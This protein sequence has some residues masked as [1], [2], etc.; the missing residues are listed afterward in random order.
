MWRQMKM[1]AGWCAIL[2]TFNWCQL[3]N[4]IHSKLWHKSSGLSRQTFTMNVRMYV[5]SRIHLQNLTKHM[6]LNVQR[7]HTKNNSKLTFQDFLTWIFSHNKWRYSANSPICEDR[8]LKLVVKFGSCSPVWDRINVRH[9]AVWMRNVPSGYRDWFWAR[10]MHP[11]A[12]LDCLLIYLISFWLDFIIS[13]EYGRILHVFYIS[14]SGKQQ[15]IW[16]SYLEVEA[17]EVKVITSKLYIA[18]PLQMTGR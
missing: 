10:P 17:P 18:S 13:V 8:K 6:Q 2:C 9:Y 11:S 4:I 15:Q 7:E 12:P 5:S 3:N 14:D 1:I 16:G